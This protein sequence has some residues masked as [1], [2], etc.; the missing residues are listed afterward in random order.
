MLYRPN[1]QRIAQLLEEDRE[2]REMLFEATN[3]DERE[4]YRQD[5][6]AVQHSLWLAGYSPED[7]P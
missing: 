1:A 6:H 7:E 3:P 4:C 2:L 5:L